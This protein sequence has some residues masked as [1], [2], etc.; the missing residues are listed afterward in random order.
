MTVQALFKKLAGRSITSA[1]KRRQRVLRHLTMLALAAVL[2]STPA[3]AQSLMGTFT[4]RG[5]SAGVP[6]ALNLSVNGGQISGVM[7]T[8]QP[9]ANPPVVNPASMVTRVQGSA[10]GTQWTVQAGAFVMTGVFN[11][12]TFSGTYSVSGQ[13]GVFSLSTS[14]PVYRA[15]VATTHPPAQVAP[16]RSVAPPVPARTLAP[17]RPVAAPAPVPAAAPATA[18]YLKGAMYYP[19]PTGTV[20][21]QLVINLI[22]NGN[23]ITGDA[24]IGSTIGGATIVGPLTANI[25]LQGTRNGQTCS[26]TLTGNGGGLKFTGPCTATTFSGTYRVGTQSGTFSVSTNGQVPAQV[27]PPPQPA[28]AAAPVPARAPTPTVPAGANTCPASGT[29]LQ[30][31]A[32]LLYAIGQPESLAFS[33]VFNGGNITGYEGQ[34]GQGYTPTTPNPLTGTISGQHCKLTVGGM[35]NGTVFDGTCNGQS[36]NGTEITSGVPLQFATNLAPGTAN[37]VTTACTQPAPAQNAANPPVIPPVQ[38]PA[39]PKP[40]QTVYCGQI[41]GPQFGNMVEPVRITWTAAANSPSTLTIGNNMPGSGVFYGII[42]PT[43]A[44]DGSTGALAFNGTCT[45]TTI[46]A[47]TRSNAAPGYGEI[48]A[49]TQRCTNSMAALPAP[50]PA[51]AAAQST[52]PRP[53]QATTPPAPAPVH[54]APAPATQ[55]ALRYCGMF[56]NSTPNMIGFRGAIEF[57]L[58]APNTMNGAV[59]IIGQPLTPNVG[60]DFGGGRIRG[61]TWSPCSGVS[62]G[63]FTFSNATCTS[64]TISGVYSIIGGNP[65]VQ[66]GSFSATATTAAACP[67]PPQAQ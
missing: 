3:L 51:P 53:T 1:S 66:N 54:P 4:A 36:F 52:P 11:G 25:P 41:T 7:G 42:S 63:G 24:G 60:S 29:A 14:A 6:I 16:A 10:R 56:V 37:A 45:S 23:N 35:M 44:C 28:T 34:A 5:Q 20:T 8:G 30:H 21:T 43:L 46:A 39:P 13:S 49:S 50:Y 9:G 15:P 31:Y 59:L 12:T 62:D 57:D 17:A 2:L 19:G 58:P 38:T 22:F 48:Q 40:G 61:G 33:L 67:Q 47:Y 18:E 32:G 55:A 26:V 64:T 65:N 27:A